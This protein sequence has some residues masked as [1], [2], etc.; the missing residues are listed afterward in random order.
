MSNRVLLPTFIICVLF[1]T[2]NI[3]A[4]DDFNNATSDLRKAISSEDTAKATEA[5]KKISSDNSERA[6]KALIDNLSTK[7]QSMYWILIAGLSNITDTKGVEYIKNS[8]LGNRPAEQ[9][10]DIL[11]SLQRNTS[12]AADTAIIEILSKGTPEL[13]VTA[14]DELTKRQK[15]EAIQPLIDLLKKEE[16]NQSE[17]KRQVERALRILTQVDFN[18]S[19]GWQDWWDKNKDVFEI[20]K[21]PNTPE[22]PTGGTVAEVIK[23]NR[24]SDYE[25]LK[26]GRAE[27]IVVVEGIFDRIQE[28][29]AKLEIPH[30]LIKQGDLVKYDLSKCMVLAINCTGEVK[31]AD[32]TPG[33]FTNYGADTIAKIR[34]F[35]ARG[36][37]LF[38]EDWNLKHILE[39]AFPGYL[40]V[41]GMTGSK[42]ED[43]AIF[44]AKGM[45][46]HPL[47]KDAF[48]RYK[49]SG[50]S[51]QTSAEIEEKLD[52]TWHVDELS[53]P[54]DYDK[55]RVTLLAESPDFG[56]KYKFPAVVVTFFYS[57][58][59][60]DV[61]T[62]S[63]Y[64]DIAKVKGGRVLH[65]LSHFG[66]QK[67]KGDEYALQ[68]MLLNFMIEA[69]DR[70]TLKKN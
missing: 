63:T 20:G 57:G 17:L 16:A 48:I 47:L 35:V 25:N 58:G 41:G 11:F 31:K 18:G 29:L 21:T 3:V 1:S 56:K 39:P 5:A 14:I 51:G 34:N 32:G 66:K 13:Q 36:G 10:K 40:K 46:S 19:S 49:E 44:P 8:I 65:V 59:D 15:K 61:H 28:I 69:G 64:Y 38:T 52:Y 12:P 23:L 30:T 55:S 70:R 60:K 53:Y 42:A 37:Y 2:G 26:K 27:D 6:A 68:N 9:K 67:T 62:G 33:E 50:E 7:S 24:H 22:S 54:I 4:Y 43:F 45:N